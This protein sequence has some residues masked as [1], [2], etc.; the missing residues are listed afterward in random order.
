MAVD[1]VGMLASVEDTAFA[2]VVAVQKDFAVDIVSEGNAAVVVAGEVL[3]AYTLAVVVIV[4]NFAA[5]VPMAV[6]GTVV[7]AKSFGRFVLLAEGIVGALDTA[8]ASLVD[9]VDKIVGSVGQAAADKIAAVSE[10]VA[11]EVDGIETALVGNLVEAV[12]GIAVDTV[13]ALADL[14]G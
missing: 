5:V 4:G 8:D 7:V 10:V 9:F 12:D 3:V 13:V 14:L 1:S 6:E 11:A 2:V